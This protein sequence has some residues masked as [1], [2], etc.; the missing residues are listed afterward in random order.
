MLLT[1]FLNRIYAACFPNEHLVLFQVMSELRD[2]ILPEFSNV[3]TGKKGII[4]ESVLFEFKE[5]V[6]MCG[7]VDEKARAA[8]LLQSLL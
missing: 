1:S 4:C 7:G 6:S 8:Q 5:L 3:I 2:P